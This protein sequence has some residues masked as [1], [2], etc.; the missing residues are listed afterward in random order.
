MRTHKTH[1][2]SRKWN[3]QWGNDK[4]HTKCN[5]RWEWVSDEASKQA[6]RQE[7]RGEEGEDEDDDVL[8]SNEEKTKCGERKKWF[9]ITF[10][11]IEVWL[12]NYNGNYLKT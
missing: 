4:D 9:K 1:A 7:M 11:L 8:A 12:V 5:Y 6:S 3:T 2:K 10:Q